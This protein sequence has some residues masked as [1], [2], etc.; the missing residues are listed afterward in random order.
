ML[1]GPTELNPK[2]WSVARLHC[3]RDAQGSHTKAGRNPCFYSLP[4][5]LRRVPKMEFASLT[6]PSL[7]GKRKEKSEKQG[8]SYI[9]GPASRRIGAKRGEGG[10]LSRPQV[11]CL[12]NSSTTGENEGRRPATG[13]ERREMNKLEWMQGIQ[14]IRRRTMGRRD[15]S[16]KKQSRQK[17][18]DGWDAWEGLGT[19]CEAVCTLVG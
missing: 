17:W 6:Y 5:P 18:E 4:D 10:R 14:G 15:R 1:R 12:L 13:W 9:H 3:P 19:S 11:V 7:W 16:C 8:G 2:V